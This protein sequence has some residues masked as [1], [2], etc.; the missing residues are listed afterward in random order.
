MANSITID[1]GIPGVPAAG[2]AASARPS[3]YRRPGDVLHLL[4]SALT[5]ILA[6]TAAAFVNHDLLGRGAWIAVGIE[7]QTAVGEL[8]TGIVQAAAILAVVLLLV[9]VLRRQR[10]RL[11][12]SLVLDGLVAA[13]LLSVIHAVF[14]ASTHPGSLTANLTHDSIVARASFPSAIYFA[15]ASAVVA[16][17]SPWLTSSWRRAAWIGVMVAAGVRVATG[18]LLPMDL[19]LAVAA[20]VTVGTGALVAFGAPDRRQRE[21]AV[22]DALRAGGLPTTSVVPAAAESKGSRPF[23]AVAIDGRRLF[24]KLLDR[25]HRDADLL[26]RTYR[27]LRLRGVDDG[28]PRLSLQ[29]AVEHQALVGCLAERAGV[30][31][32][33]VDRLLPASDEGQ[34]LVMDQ[35]AG[36]SLEQVPSDALTDG[37]LDD[38]WANVGR[39]HQAGIAHRSLRTANLM[40]DNDERTWIVD[41]SFADRTGTP[42]QMAVDVAELLAS[43]STRIDPDRAVAH[44]VTALGP[45]AVAAAGPLLQP[46]ALSAATKQ[47]VTA[48]DKTLLARLRES[49]SAATDRPVEELTKLQRVKP[50][51]VLTIVGLAAAFYYLL[52]QLANVGSSWKAFQSADWSWLIVIV[53]MSA[54]TYVAAAVGAMGCVPDRLPFGPTLAT[55]VG[56]SFVNRVTP[57]SIG[58]MA[59]NVRFMQRA[60]VEPAV[61]VAGVGLNSLAGGIV[62]LF[63]MVV[64]FSWAG[65]SLGSAFH[66]PSSSKLL[67]A[68]AVL[69]AIVGLLMA[70]RWGRRKVISKLVRGLRSSMAAFR[71]IAQKPTK[72]ALLFGGSMAVTL[73]YIFAFNASVAAFGGGISEAKL[74]A[75]FLGA[76]ALAA[77]S[78]TPGNLGALEAAMVAG[79]TG[80][81]M[82]PG[83][84]VSAVLTYRVATYWL[85]VLPG[86]IAWQLIQKW[87]YV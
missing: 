30:R 25:D 43:L 51:T 54:V 13:A 26:Y 56:S 85:P 46:L 44:A 6:T 63:L 12:A 84:A 53:A 36:T 68:L 57:A 65:N 1:I 11:L 70:T 29:D 49:V 4:V 18:A 16:T 61:A 87:D 79:L 64:C 55:Q 81:G 86:W 39:L 69:A 71:H 24:V 73:A 27:F 28:R 38:L 34:L 17:A 32:P 21:R 2:T 59:L 23:E 62:H 75:V 40:M 83:L 58:G 77:A 76:S 37:V 20:G 72:V 52:P 35:V 19:V 67:V 60:G 82:E 33:H 45:D 42:R 78:P 47:A 9:G 22:A 5:L 50:T 66:L 48:T 80:V 10:Y 14:G 15:A 41:F 31:V 8:L 3:R 74:G 7:P